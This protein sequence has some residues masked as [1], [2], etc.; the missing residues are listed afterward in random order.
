MQQNQE[1]KGQQAQGQLSDLGSGIGDRVAGTVGGAVAG[2]TGNQAEE[3]KRRAQHD[4]GK[5]L[6]RGVEA[7]VQKEAEAQPKQ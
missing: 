2:L 4:Q 3:A 6:Q 1:G 7:E 5:T